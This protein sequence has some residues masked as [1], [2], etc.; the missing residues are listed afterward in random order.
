LRVFGEKVIIAGDEDKS[1]PL[2]VVR[3]TAGRIQAR[4]VVLEE[5]GHWLVM[6]DLEGVGRVVEGVFC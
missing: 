5:V 4:L 2:S 1:A 3:K 6:E